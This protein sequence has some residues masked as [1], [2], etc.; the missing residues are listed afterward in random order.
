MVNFLYHLSR[1]IIRHIFGYE[2]FNFDL[3]DFIFP[4]F[5]DQLKEFLSFLN[6]PEAPSCDHTLK[7]AAQWIEDNKLDQDKVIPW[8]NDNGGFCD[9]EVISNVYDAVGDIVEWHLDEE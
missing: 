2:F 6:R 3:I 4:H 5:F 8:L 9:C 1:C 7:E